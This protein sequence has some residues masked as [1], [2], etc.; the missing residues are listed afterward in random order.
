MTR[1]YRL[2][3]FAILMLIAFAML[4][5]ARAITLNAG[6]PP[7]TFNLDF[8][9]LTFT[10][11]EISSTFTPDFS[12]SGERLSFTKYVD[13]ASPK[14]CACDF[15]NSIDIFGGTSAVAIFNNLTGTGVDD[16]IFSV[17]L[18]LQFPSNPPINL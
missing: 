7:L 14:L 6:G 18:A 15:F 13:K 3:P 10:S 17:Q 9:G 4:H 5:P 8:T 16:A 11:V 12:G 2:V 1:N